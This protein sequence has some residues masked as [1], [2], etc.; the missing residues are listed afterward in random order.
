MHG[1][2]VAVARGLLAMP[3]DRRLAR[4][5]SLIQHAHA[6][7]KYF[8]RFGRSH[9]RWG[10]GSL[11]SIA[12]R[13]PLQPEPSFSVNEYCRCFEVVLICLVA[14]RLSRTHN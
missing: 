12:H 4:C 7:H 11:M 3:D 8:K 1:D 2:V 14:W 6:A 9:Q 13:Y 10:D 5:Q